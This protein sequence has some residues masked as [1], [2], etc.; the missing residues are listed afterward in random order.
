LIASTAVIIKE[1][2]MGWTCSTTGGDMKYLQ[3]FVETLVEWNGI[4]LAQD[5]D[6]WIALVM[7]VLNIRFS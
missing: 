6:G 7:T 5:R 4:H 1:D 3:S 2:V